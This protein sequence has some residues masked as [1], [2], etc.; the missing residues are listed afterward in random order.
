MPVLPLVAMTFGRLRSPNTNVE[1]YKIVFVK[2]EMLIVLT[3]IWQDGWARKDHDLFMPQNF[4]SLV[5]SGQWSSVI[6]HV[7]SASAAAIVCWNGLSQLLWLDEL[8]LGQ[9]P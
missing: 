2:P 1:S 8:A 7:R 6:L 5:R 3:V 4:Q 9:L